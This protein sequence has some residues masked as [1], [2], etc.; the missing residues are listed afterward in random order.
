MIKNRIRE[1]LKERGISEKK[2][3]EHMGI[4]AKTFKKLME[5]ETGS[6]KYEYIESVCRFLNVT[7]NDVLEWE[8][9]K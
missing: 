2:L 3:M 5:N 8:R 1:I 4:G 7:P 6:I 9:T